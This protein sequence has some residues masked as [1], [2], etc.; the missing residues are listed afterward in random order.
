M[1]A[2]EDINKRTARL[3]ANIPFIKNNLIPLSFMNVKQEAYIKSLLGVY[4]KNDVSLFRD[5]YLWPYKR[6]L[7]RVSA[8]Q[9]AMGEPDG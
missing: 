6:S 7:L 8:I 5:L 3:V 4:E 2:F 9:E 1:Q